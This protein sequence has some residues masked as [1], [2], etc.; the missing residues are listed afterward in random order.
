M[1]NLLLRLF[2]SEIELRYKCLVDA[3]DLLFR[4]W[5]DRVFV[6]RAS[7]EINKRAPKVVPPPTLRRI[8]KTAEEMVFFVHGVKPAEESLP[9]ENE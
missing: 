6:E 4:Q 8:T 5:E 1:G 3:R 7:A 9:I 2:M